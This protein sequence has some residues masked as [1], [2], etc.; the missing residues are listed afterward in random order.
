MWLTR[1]SLRRLGFSQQR[2][3]LWICEGSYG[4]PADAHLSTWLWVWSAESTDLESFH[5]TIPVRRERAHFYYREEGHGCWV[6]EGYTPAR[7]I[8]RM[9]GE[10][11]MLLP[12]ADRAAQ[13]LVCALGGRLLPR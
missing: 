13:S 7:D 2:D 12:R 9:G 5:V 3:A 1:S 4:L 11:Q 8:R 10:P 6:C